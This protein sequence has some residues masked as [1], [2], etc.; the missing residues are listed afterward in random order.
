MS[1]ASKR[2]KTRNQDRRADGSA[3]PRGIAPAACLAPAF[4]LA[5]W[6]VPLLVL[7]ATFVTFLPV[8]DAEFVSWDDDKNIVQNPYYKGLSGEHLSWILSLKNFKMGH[9]QPLSW[10]TLAID[11]TFWKMDP[12]GYHRTNLLFHCATALAIYFLA[13]RLFRITMSD[14]VRKV[15]GIAAICAGI[16]A[17]LFSLHPL[18]AESVAW[19]TERRDVQSGLFFVLTLVAYLKACTL[20]RDRRLHLGWYLA[21]VLCLLLS[22][23]SKAWGMTVPAVLILLDVYPLRRLGKSVRDWFSFPSIMV[24]LQKVPFVLLAAFS[25]AQ[26]ARAQAAG[27][28]TMK[29]L[30]EHSIL[31]RIGQAF[32]GLGFYLHKTLIPTNLHPIYEIPTDFTG[33]EPANLISALVVVAITVALFASR[34]RWP[35]VLAAWIYYVAVVSPV[36]GLL[37]SGPQLVKDS[38]TYLCCIAWGILL[39]AGILKLAALAPTPAPD[40]STS[41]DRT[42]PHPSAVA[43]ICAVLV[44]LCGLA[45]LTW[46]QSAFWKDSPTLF[47]RILS[48]APDS[49]NGNN[50]MG[51]LL[52]QRR[53][54]QGAIDHFQR[55][56][57]RRPDKAN[58]YFNMGNS[59][60]ALKQYDQAITAFRK[61]IDLNP[62][63][64]PAH[65]N[66]ANTLA[67]Q[68]DDHESALHHFKKALEC[69]LNPRA[70][71]YGQK[72][73]TLHYTIAFE[74]NKLGRRDQA[75]AYLNKCLR[76]EPKHKL[77]NKLKRDMEL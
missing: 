5:A 29:T 9:F 17:L 40:A 3:P 63:L 57:A 55:A 39:A 18:R 19:V 77:G 23:G 25:A 45:A 74:L 76:S 60:K 14:S 8:L 62:L 35:A 68:F 6:V 66:L 16:A 64:A 13:L 20:R 33:L 58:P 7:A 38:Y 47:T 44:L 27:F 72:F 31:S 37:Q 34:K 26:A 51:I 42:G 48:I 70:P 28:G 36:L 71:A 21:S 10:F 53:Q 32:Y 56:I 2:R 4:G 11:Y 65:F 52:R 1:K 12:R 67:S 41:P 75:L 69:K 59:F 61:A 73:S 24:W 54:Y 46:R 22:L 30:A 49:F 43:A 15:P 50:N